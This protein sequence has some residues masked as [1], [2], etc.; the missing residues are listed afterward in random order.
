M[1]FL[2]NL[3]H[4]FRLIENRFRLIKTDRDSPLFFSTI[5]IDR[6]TGWINRNSG[7]TDFFIYFLNKPVF[8]KTP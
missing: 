1:I 5:L 2:K 6:K 3:T 8:E 4:D 7:K